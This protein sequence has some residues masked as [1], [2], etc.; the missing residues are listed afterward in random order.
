MAERVLLV[1]DEMRIARWAQAYIEKAG[2]S[3]LWASN[4]EDALHLARREHPDLIVLDL[5]LPGVDGWTVC[6]ELRK[7]SDVPI[8][9][10]TARVAEQDIV[11]GLKMGADDYIT[12]PF[13]PGELVARIEATLRRAKGKFLSA[14]NRLVAGPFTLD[15][16]TRQCYLES[17]PV[18]LTVRQFEL[19]AF[20][21]RHPRQVLSRE[22]LIDHVFGDDF[23]SDER[24]IDIHIRRLRIKVEPDPSAPRYIQTVFGMGY[25]FNPE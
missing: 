3:C 23:A 1:E 22:Q 17:R 4:G 25:R 2:Y 14:G 7:E 24:A 8:V 12:K 19:L 16:E 20:F 9:M 15:L 18:T 5:M 21:M 10:L 13:Q 11:N 6:R